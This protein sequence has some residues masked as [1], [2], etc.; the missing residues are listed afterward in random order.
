MDVTQSDDFLNLSVTQV[1]EWISS[2]DII[3]KAEEEV[4][5]VVVKWTEK[6]ENRKHESFFKL[7]RLVRLVYLSRNY[8]FNVIFP[9]PLVKGSATCTELVLDSM[10]ELSYGTEEC[11]FVQPPRS[12][13]KTHEDA[14]VACGMKTKEALCYLP[15]EKSWYKLAGMTEIL[16]RQQSIGSVMSACHGKLYIATVSVV[17]ECTVERYD[18]SGN[19][20]APVKSL[21]EA[22][23][24]ELPAVVTFQGFLY[25]VGGWNEEDTD[26]VHKYNPDTNLW[27]E[28]APMSVARRSVC[29]LADRNSLY[30]IGGCSEDTILDVVEKFDPEKNCW[31]RIAST[32]EKRAN[33]CGAVVRGKVFLFGGFTDIRSNIIQHHFRI[34]LKYMT[35]LQTCGV[36]LNVWVHHHHHTFSV[37]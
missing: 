35:H 18:P 15:L 19:S 8:V 1:E 20:W 31:K 6:A 34:L 13:L 30:A 2:D 3:V 11:F 10:K 24:Y 25:V 14:I 26:R 7:F 29:G 27:Q 16:S 32:L 28:V 33:A 22:A 17:G 36:A 23:T 12:C 9:H 37:L 5:E 4:F 21:A